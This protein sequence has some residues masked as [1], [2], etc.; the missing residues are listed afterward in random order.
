[1][2]IKLKDS[3]KQFIYKT[4]PPPYTNQSYSQAGED[5]IV[6]FLFSQLG[7]TSPTYLELGVYHPKTGSNTYKFYTNG[8]KGVL[9][10]ADKTL[11][12]EIKD[13]RPNDIILNYGVGTG[14]SAE[15]EFYIFEEPAHST[16][17]KSEADNRVKT[18][19]YKLLRT[20][21]VKLKNIN[22]ILSENFKTVPHF[23][24]IDIE[25]LDLSVLKTLDFNKFPIPVICAETCTY[26]E[27]HIK[28]KDKTIHDFML[29]MGYFI[30]A[31]TYIN[32][33]FV[34]SNWFH[35]QN[36]KK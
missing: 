35:S 27:N 18:G 32:T 17:D 24:S 13:L 31:D 6:N 12:H 20:E 14:E 21:K 25:G 3:I 8:G 36:I 10:E 4:I 23:L 34:N 19:S 30:Y 7:I 16:F 26:S 22:T 33:I 9:V 28:P 11:I 2:L 1:M 29:N 5:C 15:A